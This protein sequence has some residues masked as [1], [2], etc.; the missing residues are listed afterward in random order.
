MGREVLRVSKNGKSTLKTVAVAA[1]AAVVGAAAGAAAVAMADPKN[2]R[3]AE[4]LVQKAAKKA[5]AVKAD[6]GEKLTEGVERT[7]AEINKKLGQLE[8]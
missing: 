7:K 1:G 4:K 5:Q 8:E 3:K 2:R 6:W